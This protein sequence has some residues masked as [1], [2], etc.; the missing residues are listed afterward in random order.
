MLDWMV[1]L[2]ARTPDMRYDTPA[3]EAS[4]RQARP[5]TLQAGPQSH[6]VQRWREG[7]D[8]AWLIAA[9]SLTAPGAPAAPWL[10]GATPGRS[11]GTSPAG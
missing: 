7:R 1:T 11:R 8:V 4:A 5:Q 2:R 3:P 9:M 10:A 6:A